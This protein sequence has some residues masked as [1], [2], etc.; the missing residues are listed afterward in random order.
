MSNIKIE[1]SDEEMLKFFHNG[2][3]VYTAQLEG[4][5]M[6]DW[7]SDG[8]HI[9]RDFCDLVVRDYK[10]QDFYFNVFKNGISDVE[11]VRLAEQMDGVENYLKLNDD[12]LHL[13]WIINRAHKAGY[14]TFNIDGLDDIDTS[15][16]LSMRLVFDLDKDPGLSLE[17]RV[18]QYEKVR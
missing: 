3:H 13:I 2:E 8:V 7:E 9:G 10:R 17:V 18:I 12:D 4:F 1:R 11:F 14:R 16:D 6:L 5:E 15:K